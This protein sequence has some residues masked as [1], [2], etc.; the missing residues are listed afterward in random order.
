MAALRGTAPFIRQDPE[1]RSLIF[2]GPL[3]SA[4]MTKTV[5]KPSIALIAKISKSTVPPDANSSAWAAASAP[6]LRC[7]RSEFS[8]DAVPTYASPGFHSNTTLLVHRESVCWS[9]SNFSSLMRLGRLFIM[10][11][12]NPVEAVR[13]FTILV[14]LRMPRYKEPSGSPSLPINP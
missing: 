3:R 11:S 14:L 5:S 6:H 7:P 9:S 4:T 12:V 13:L 1:M 10:K 8:A 2:A